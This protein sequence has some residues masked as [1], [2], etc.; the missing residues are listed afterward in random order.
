MFKFISVVMIF[1]FACCW[2][3]AER[4]KC[5]ADNLA[6]LKAFKPRIPGEPFYLSWQHEHDDYQALIA[7]A[8][9]F[10]E[11]AKEKHLQAL[12]YSDIGHMTARDLSR[13]YAAVRYRINATDLD[14]QMVQKAVRSGKVTHYVTVEE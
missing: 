5:E 1:I 8:V 10:N 11:L 9:R 4:V 3:N 6:E 13:L 2:A 14:G 12:S 7:E